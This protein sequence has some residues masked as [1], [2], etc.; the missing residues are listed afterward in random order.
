MSERTV[1]SGDVDLHVL[2]SG[3]AHDRDS[4][5]TVVLLHGWPDSSAIW[6]QQLTT[7]A[8]AGYRVIAPDLRGFGRSSRSLERSAYAMD[9]LVADVLAVLDD[10]GAERAEVVGHDWGSILAWEVALRAPERVASLTAISVGHPDGFTAGGLAQLRR[11][12]Y[13]GAFVV[14]G[15]AERLLPARGWA[16]LRSAWSGQRPEQAPGLARQI[17]DLSRPGAIT[18]GVNWYRANVPRM[19]GSS[20]A[21]RGAPPRLVA[22]PTMGIWSSEDAALTREQMLASERF[23]TGPWRF[24][25]IDGVDHWIPERAGDALDALLLDFLAT[26]RD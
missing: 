5:A 10:A 16:F 7:L 9:R 19:V 23:V 26:A 13:M 1:T 4:A 21:R 18:S 14:P 8:A 17:T 6:E 20:L 22:A 3:A 24:E 2:S 15:L 11:S 12:W 25:Q